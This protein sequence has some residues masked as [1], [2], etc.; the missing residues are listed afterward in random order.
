MNVCDVNKVHF[1]TDWQEPEWLSYERDGDDEW[2]KLVQ[3]RTCNLC[4]R[5]QFRE[6]TILKGP[7]P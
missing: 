7:T 6:V 2:R 3:R 5:V 1:D 4:G